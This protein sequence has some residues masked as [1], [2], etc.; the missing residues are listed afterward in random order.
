[1]EYEGELISHIDYE[2]VF[3]T[4]DEYD[5]RYKNGS[6]KGT[7]KKRRKFFKVNN[8]R[9]PLSYE[10]RV[11]ENNDRNQNSAKTVP[12]IYFILN[13]F[14]DHKDLLREYFESII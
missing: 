9:I 3:Y 4:V 11:L 1:M 14:F 2:K 5:N 12:F 6:V 13:S 10:C 8:A 7:G